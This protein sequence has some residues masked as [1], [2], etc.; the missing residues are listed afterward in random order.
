MVNLDREN[1][2]GR[3]GFAAA[4]LNILVIEFATWVLMSGIYFAV[5]LVPALL[6][7]LGLSALLATRQGRI[8]EV[9]RGLLIG[10][11]AGPA[12]IVVFVPSFLLAEK[13]GLF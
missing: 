5:Y 4:L 1:P 11:I 7:D 6:V 8:R 2:Y 13:V 10:C 3:A 12:A 9:G